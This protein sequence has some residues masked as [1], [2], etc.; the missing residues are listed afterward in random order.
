MPREKG[1]EIKVVGK[2]GQISLGKRCAGK[3]LHLQRRED[4]SILITS[5]S[6]HFRYWD[7]PTLFSTASLSIRT[8][9]SV[10]SS[11]E[12][13]G[14]RAP[15]KLSMKGCGTGS[16]RFTGTAFTEPRRDLQ[17]TY[18]GGSEPRLECQKARISTVSSSTF[19]R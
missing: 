9:A 7:G 2:S 18:K 16:S 12:S 14:L 6:R 10:S 3:T 11:T 5:R 8:R 4:G 13:S 1:A 15:R 17:T 19:K